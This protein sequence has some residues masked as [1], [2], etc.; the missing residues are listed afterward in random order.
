MSFGILSEATP[1]MNTMRKPS[2]SRIVLADETLSADRREHLLR[3]R[4][5][6]VSCLHA[7]EIQ[8]TSTP[9]LGFRGTVSHVP[10]GSSHSL[11]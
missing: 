8:T 6:S 5:F 7:S 1:L 4:E 10:S 11:P 3:N 2:P 9:G